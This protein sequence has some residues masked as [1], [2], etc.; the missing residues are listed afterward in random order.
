MTSSV[1]DC[2]IAGESENAALPEDAQDQETKVESSQL[3]DD[4]L[5]PS[6]PQLEEKTIG[7]LKFSSLVQFKLS[8]KKSIQVLILYRS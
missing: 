1:P 3:D 7:N 4:V 2:D 6:C 5:E 8:E